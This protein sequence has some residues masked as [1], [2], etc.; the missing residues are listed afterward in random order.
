MIAGTRIPIEKASEYGIM[1][2]DENSM[3]KSFVEKPANPEPMADDPNNALASMGVYVVEKEFLFKYLRADGLNGES[4]HD[5]GRSII[6]KIHADE[7]ETIATYD[8]CSHTISGEN[9]PF[10]LDV[11]QISDYFQAHM[12]LLKIVPPLSMYNP[13]WPILTA[14]DYTPGAKFNIPHD[15]WTGDESLAEMIAIDG[16]F[17]NWTFKMNRAIITGQCIFDEPV[18]LTDVVS[19]KGVRVGKFSE[20]KKCIIHPNASIGENCSLKN[21]IILS[22][23]KIPDNTRI[24]HDENEDKM[25]NIHIDSNSGVRVIAPENFS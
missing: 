12:D 6:P 25:R 15:N 1:S 11:G 18:N 10:W 24:G 16:R 22:G 7:P 20:L 5:F 3:L 2:A 4:K 8:F 13:E 9:G 23:C 19:S 17:Q 14:T 21:T